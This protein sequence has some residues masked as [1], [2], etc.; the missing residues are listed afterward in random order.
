MDDLEETDPGSEA[1]G[2]G[3]TGLR[4]FER[5]FP[6][7]TLRARFLLILFGVLLPSLTLFGVLHH[8]LVKRALLE[9]VDQSLRARALEVT[10]V[11][12]DSRVS[13][14]DQLSKI[15]LREVPLALGST[16][17][18][19]VDIIDSQGQLLWISENLEGQPIPV[20][21]EST[22]E[23][24]TLATLSL[25]DGLPLRRLTQPHRLE[26]GDT[27]TIVVAE[28]LFHM[29][30][31]LRASVG[32]SVLL[33][34]LILGLTELA[35]SW[36]LSGV[37]APLDTLVGTAER[38]VSTDDVTQ[39]VPI[40]LGS[41]QEIR[42]TA[43]AFNRLM[44]RVEQLLETARRLL[45]DTSHELRNPLTVLMTDLDMLR[46]ELDAEDREAVVSEAQDTVRRMT[47][48]VSDL[49]QLTRTEAHSEHISVEAVDVPALVRKV[50][51]RL[52]KSLDGAQSVTVIPCD[53]ECVG[54]I[55]RQ[56][57]EQILTNL[58]ENAVRYTSEGKVDVSVFREGDQI[59]IS[60]QDFGT[61]IPDAEREKIFERFYRVDQSRNRH[62]G[63]TGLGL[64]LARALAR[65]QGGDV[66]LH[67]RTGKG[68][69]FRVTVP[70]A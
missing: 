36:L 56:R 33:G 34:V 39:R 49:L 68:A 50:V 4:P 14:V 59:V 28:S 11:L 43:V 27:V 64:P 53:E 18:V 57:T 16:P 70:V 55:D 44:D 31:A 5:S 52:A 65:S 7:N 61:G 63:G 32:R 22:A 30:Q 21:L 23:Q 10:N 6:F 58:V 15:H 29:E 42:R 62:S 69:D 60:V 24:S 46:K 1:K 9:E 25:P 20:E 41:Q 13:S 38:I 54:M 37:F 51:G 12:R 47:R 66:R 35:G 40:A 26:G 17:E 19:Y 3:L 8:D 45:A 48:L 2:G 67:S